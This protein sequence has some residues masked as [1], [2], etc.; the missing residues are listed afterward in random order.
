M[1]RNSEPSQ[2]IPTKKMEKRENT[3]EW[4]KTSQEKIPR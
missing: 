1:E 3:E 4:K 2:G